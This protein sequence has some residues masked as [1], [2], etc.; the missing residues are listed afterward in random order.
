MARIR[1]YMVPPPAGRFY[2]RNGDDT[3]EARTWP[4]MTSAMKAYMATHPSVQGSIED[5]VS[6]CMCPE[7]PSWYCIG[8]GPVRPPVRMAEARV[9]AEKYFRLPLVPFDRVSARLRTCSACRACH[10]RGVCLTCTGALKW[11]RS[12]FPGG[13]PKVLEDDLSGI[14]START[15]E[16]VLASVEHPVDADVSKFP[17]GCWM[18]TERSGTK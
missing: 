17:E 2:F 14:C 10:E 12:R 1:S 9:N 6:G 5:L 18:R 15:F 13:R 7:A 16:S 3:V 4:E 8:A 11:I